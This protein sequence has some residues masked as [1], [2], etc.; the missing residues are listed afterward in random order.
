MA[1]HLE[2]TAGSVDSAALS[3]RRSGGRAARRAASQNDN[4]PLAVEVGASGGTYKPL[5]E[6]DMERIHETAL[7]VLENIGVAEPVPRFAEAAEKAGCTFSDTGR[8]LF[9]RALVED[10]IAQTPETAY[11]LSRDKKRDLEMKDH[12]VHFDPGGEAV[13]TLDVGADTYRASTILDLYDFARLTDS[14]DHIDSFGRLVVPT[15]ITDLHAHDINSAYAA[16]SGTT[17]HVELGFMDYRHMDDA[18]EMAYM[19]AGGEKA[20]YDHPF[21]SSGGCPVVSPLTYGEENSEV[22]IEAPRFGAPVAVIIAPQA[23]ATSPAALAGTLVQ[24]MAET[25]SA[26]MLVQLTTPGHPVLFGMWPFVSD[27]R[28]GSFTGG[29]GEQAILAAAASQIANFYG[30]PS[31]VGAGMTDSKAVDNQAGFERGITTVLAALAGTN[32][33]SEVGGTMGSL[34]GCSFEAMVI[35]ND[36]IGMIKR[37]LR[38]I[39]VTDETL[40]YQVIKDAVEGPGH[41]LGHSQTLSLMNTE[42]LYP[43]LADRTSPG[44]WEE[45]GSRDIRE[46]AGVRAREILSKHYPTHI[47]AATDRAIRDRFSILL[48]EE[49]M[50]A[51]SGRW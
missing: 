27:L 7:D 43:A 25:L 30:L 23:G 20:Y 28:T 14:L 17:K 38:G 2:A 35:D 5:S 39:E 51:N 26:L 45:K 37:V 10:C 18:L 31:S 13:S 6:R 21:C 50:K 4:A 46:Q 8:V 24:T 33:I 49:A 15:E 40:S 9:P 3:G 12:R 32:S 48:P 41:Y 34:M 36:M 29:S 22:C 11:Y 1:T 47:D 44:E 19:V 42:Y 16:M